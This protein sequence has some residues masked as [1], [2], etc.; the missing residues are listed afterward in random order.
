MTLTKVFFA[1]VISLVFCSYICAELKVTKIIKGNQSF[2]IIL[3]DDIKLSNISLKN[4]NIELPV[5]ISKN[6]TYKQLG[7]LRREFR[8]YLVNSLSQNKMSSKTENTTFKINKLSPLKKHPTIKAFT[9]VIFNNDIEV[10]CR[11]M[12]GKNGLWIAWPSNKKGD[13]WIKEFKFINKDLKKMVEKKLI[14]SY[15]SIV[16]SYDKTKSK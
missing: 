4:N 2:D 5:Y 8:Q 9:S 16:N 11:I 14:S 10:G 3:N 6:K 15:T 12:Q 13:V 7:I 1:I